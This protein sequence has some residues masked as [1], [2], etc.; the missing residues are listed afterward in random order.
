MAAWINGA[1]V[2]REAA[3]EAAAAVIAEARLP[4][5]A[6][7]VADVDGIRAGIRLAEVVG[8]IVDPFASTELYAALAGFAASG[9]IGTT[10]AEALARADFILAIGE[11]AAASSMLRRLASRG[12]VTGGTAGATR[13]IVALGGVPPPEV[14]HLAYPLNAAGLPATI[15]LLR[16]VAAGRIAADPDVTALAENLRTARFGVVIYDPGELGELASQMLIELLQELNDTARCFALPLADAWQGQCVV[17]VS[18]W[19]TGLPPRQGFG[20]GSAEH[21]PW[22]FDLRR[23]V[24]AGEVDAVIWLASLEAPVPAGSERPEVALLG[25]PT[26]EEAHIVIEVAVPG[27]TCDGAVWDDGRGVLAYR[28]AARPEKAITAADALG[29]LGCEALRLRQAPC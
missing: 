19:T 8:G 12:P 23:A 20:R 28:A 24:S 17:Q 13:R 3:L 7:L 9:T 29:R 5:I 27:V 25:E 21:D 4:A 14:E 10:P 26:G 6:G 15:G 18:A 2:D 1:R 16:A 11:A 22:R